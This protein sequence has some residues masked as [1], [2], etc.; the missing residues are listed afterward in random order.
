[1]VSEMR[2]HKLGNVIFIVF[3]DPIW[4]LRN[5]LVTQIIVPLYYFYPRSFFCLL[6]D[7]FGNLFIR[8]SRLDK[9]FELLPN[10]SAKLKK[11]LSRG[12][13][14][15]YSPLVPASVAR[16]LSRIRPAR[17]YPPRVSRGL[18]GKSLERSFARFF[19]LLVSIS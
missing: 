3:L 8:S 5:A 7:P 13:L 4:H 15:W 2:R 10:I 9:R 14:K 19:N 18:R 17:T 1:M 16:H 11:K 12:Q 6:L